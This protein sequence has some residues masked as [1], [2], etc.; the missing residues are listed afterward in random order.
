MFD[1]APERRAAPRGRSVTRPA[2]AGPKPVTSG[3][4][5]ATPPSPVKTPTSYPSTWRA[6]RPCT[7]T[8]V[9]RPGAKRSAARDREMKSR[10]PAPVSCSRLNGILN[11]PACTWAARTVRTF[12][13]TSRQSP[14][15]SSSRST[16]NSRCDVSVPVT[17]TLRRATSKSISPG[18][19][20]G[21]WRSPCTRAVSATLT[22]VPRR[23]VGRGVRRTAPA[24]AACERAAAGSGT[25]AA[26]VCAASGAAAVST[27]N[28]A[29][30]RSR[31]VM[32]PAPR[33]DH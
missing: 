25:A 14:P 24:G 17:P 7:A 29:S 11:R 9:L 23:S 33:T 32:R 30:G 8:P 19:P 16:S 2:T 21:A 27:R 6:T 26:D 3:A 4:V 18:V 28:P 10:L 20:P 31:A 1:N 22:I 12:T 5:G 13:N 15:S